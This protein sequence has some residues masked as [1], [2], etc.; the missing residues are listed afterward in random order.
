MVAQ[1]DAKFDLGAHDSEYTNT[2]GECVAWEGTNIRDAFSVG[3]VAPVDVGRCGV[4]CHRAVVE[5]W[6]AG[7]ALL[8]NGLL[9]LLRLLLLLLWLLLLWLL[10]LW[11]LCPCLHM[12]DLPFLDILERVVVVVRGCRCRGG[13]LN[14]TAHRDADFDLRA[15]NSEH[16]QTQVEREGVCEAQTQGAG[17]VSFPL[18]GCCLCLCCCWGCRACRACI[19]SFFLSRAL[20][21]SSSSSAGAAAAGAAG[22]WAAGR[23]AR[24]R[25]SRV[26]GSRAPEGTLVVTVRAPVCGSARTVR[27][28]SLRRCG[29]AAGAGRLDS[30]ASFR[31]T[32]SRRRRSFLMRAWM[33]C[34]AFSS[35]SRLTSSI[36][37]SFIRASALLISQDAHTHAHS[38]TLRIKKRLS[39]CSPTTSYGTHFR[40]FF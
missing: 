9:W 12:L 35:S 6:L 2:R 14:M 26:R 31:L 25:G 8:L 36:S 16:T 1:W 32:S 21:G 37:R 19:W 11:L 40:G 27:V 30:C 33:A 20:N 39:C 7:G 24:G 3:L 5:A 22:V 10:L 17:A 18:R 23:S 13:L 28:V 38:V 34:I 29:A 4:V 15:H